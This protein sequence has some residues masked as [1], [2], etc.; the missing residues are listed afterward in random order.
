MFKNRKIV[1]TALTL[2]LM[3]T[4]LP[5]TSVSAAET[6]TDSITSF[7]MMTETKVDVNSLSSLKTMFD[8]K[9]KVHK[10]AELKLIETISDSNH[11]YLYDSYMIQVDNFDLTKPGIQE[12][13]IKIKKAEIT[14]KAEANTQEATA[15]VGAFELLVQKE[16]K[17]FHKN[18]TYLEE[19]KTR[20]EV[21][22]TQAPV[23]QLKTS[24]IEIMEGETLDIA[25]YV[26]S[27]MDNV[28]GKLTDFKISTDLNTNVAGNY[29]ATITASDTQN[30]TAEAKIDIT[31]KKNVGQSIIQLSKQYLGTPYV[32]GGAAPGGFDC[33]GLIQYVYGQHGIYIPRVAA[34]Q[35]Y[36]GQAMNINDI[37]S[38]K[39]GD[40]IG[41]MSTTNGNI[42][43]VSMY[44]GNGQIIQSIAG[45][46]QINS[47]HQTMVDGM[48]GYLK[49]V[50]VQRIV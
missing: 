25:Q 26:D 17:T 1:M 38:W 32:W 2:G 40:I 35:S 10:D 39:P 21:V 30:N 29:Q 23:I 16:E 4:M 44:I 14:K 19:Y 47:V 41:Y 22:D 18:E 37:N 33:S 31:V 8:G 13:S 7:M 9:V 3:G 46:V 50:R 27:V 11:I 15:V 36:Y 20:V 42:T 45:G 48:G 5:P 34:S 24:S 28:D 49:I 6:K 43:H 12:A